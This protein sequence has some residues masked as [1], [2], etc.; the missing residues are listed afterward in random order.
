MSKNIVIA[1]I[2]IIL[3]FAIVFHACSEE[4]STPILETP[5]T[6]I[7]PKEE[8]KDGFLGE[9]R[10]ISSTALVTEMGVGW[11]MGNSFDVRDQDKTVWGNPL[12]SSQHIRAVKEMGFTTLRIPV[13]WNYQMQ[14]RSPYTIELPYLSRVKIIVDEGLKND[15]HVIINTHHDDWIIPTDAEASE[16][17]ARLSSLWTQIAD[18]FI[19][20]GDK[21]IFEVMNEPRLYGSPEEWSGGTAEGRR[22]VNEYTQTSLDAIR[23]TGQNNRT[24]HIMI[25]TYA[26]S[27]TSNAFEGLVIP[28][29]PNLI[30]SVHSYFPWSFA[31]QDAG[32]T[33]NWGTDE[34]KAALDS[35]LDRIM[36]RWMVQENRPV[37]L[38]E[39]GAKD[40]N[41]L[42]TRVGYTEYY[43]TAAV[44][45][46]LLPIIWDD[47]GQFGL[48]DRHALDW[49]YPEIAR[50]VVA[51]GK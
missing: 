37:V 36:E 39:Y 27:S 29:D 48:Y 9:M 4:Q 19:D 8:V 17:K 10:G 33:N 7:D 44:S 23:A 46:G 47:G 21:L 18:H 26:A 6:P 14:D 49:K 30:I 16:V 31:G 40:K 2:K 3:A 20:Y 28:D 43:T 38:G 34:D 12:P 22:L 41:N 24:R 50:S 35:E 5:E 32:G 13:T 45:R 1:F 51:A 15:M 42:S 25:P 11:N